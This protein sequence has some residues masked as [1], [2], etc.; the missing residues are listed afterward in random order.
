MYVCI[1]SSIQRNGRKADVFLT[2]VDYCMMEVIE[3]SFHSVTLANTVLAIST[4]YRFVLPIT[5]IVILLV[6]VLSRAHSVKYHTL[7]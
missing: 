7:C 2:D 1:D 5:P 4:N 3:N 6:T